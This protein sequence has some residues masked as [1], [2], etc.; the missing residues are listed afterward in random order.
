MTGCIAALSRLL[1]RSIKRVHPFFHLLKKQVNFKW[2]EE[3]KRLFQDLKKFLVEPPIL[4]KTGEGE[5]LYVYLL[6][7]ERAISSILV[8]EEHEQ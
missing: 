8:R 3:C 6:V 4:S 5:P 2:T 7:T 1:S